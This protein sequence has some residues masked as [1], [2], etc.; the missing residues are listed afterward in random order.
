MKNA[1]M[2]SIFKKD[3]NIQKGSSTSKSPSK[4][5]RQDIAHQIPST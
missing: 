4:T 1:D 2:P 3:E 5:I